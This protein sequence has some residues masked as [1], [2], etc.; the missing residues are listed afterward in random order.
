MEVNQF[1]VILKVNLAEKGEPPVIQYECSGF[2]MELTETTVEY[3]GVHWKYI[4]QHRESTVRVSE[5]TVEYLSAGYHQSK[6]EQL[7][8]QKEGG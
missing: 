8:H 4:E 5:C 1:F 6:M 7:P 3:E 2:A